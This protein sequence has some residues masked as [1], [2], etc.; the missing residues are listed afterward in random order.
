MAESVYITSPVG[1]LQIVEI[2]EEI[3]AIH[4][5]EGEMPLQNETPTAV[6][7]QCINELQEYF[8]GKRLQFGFPMMQTG[9][10]FQQRVWQQLQQIPFGE[11]ISYMQLAVQLGDAKCIRA[12]G[13]ANGKNQLSIVVPCHRVIGSNQSLIGYAGGLWRKEWLL[14]H[15]GSFPRGLSKEGAVNTQ[16][17]N[18]F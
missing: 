9:T 6:Q 7:Q 10:P 12:A 4:F 15:E 8:E 16:Q 2:D 17:L 11:T 1:V 14:R 5:T 18:L 13:T 3:A